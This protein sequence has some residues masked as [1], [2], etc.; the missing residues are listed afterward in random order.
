MWIVSYLP[1]VLGDCEN[2]VINNA[3]ELMLANIINMTILCLLL[4]IIL[5]FIINLYYNFSNSIKTLFPKI[6]ALIKIIKYKAGNSYLQ[7]LLMRIYLFIF[8]WLLSVT[9]SRLG[10]GYFMANKI[11]SPAKCKFELC[12]Y[13]SRSY[14]TCKLNSKEFY[15]WLSGF[16]DA[17]GC[18][19]I[20]RTG[21]KIKRYYLF[22]YIIYLHTD[23]TP[24]L[25]FIQKTLG[26]GKVTSM[27]GGRMS[28]LIIQSQKEVEEII[29]IFSNYT[30]QSSKLL[31]FLEFK[32]AFEL[33]NNHSEK[34]EELFKKIEI[35]KSRMNRKRTN[36]RMPKGH[37]YHITPNWLLGFTEG[38]GS[39]L[40]I[41]TK[42][43]LTFK[44]GQSGVDLP[45][46]KAIR[47]YFNSFK[48][49]DKKGYYADS[50]VVVL[51]STKPT[52]TKKS[53]VNFTIT[54]LDFIQYHLIPF[55]DSLIWHSK[56]QNDYKDFKAILNLKSKGLHHTKEGFKLI[57]LILSQNNSR[58]LSTSNIPKVNRTLLYD[59]I[60]KLLKG[61]SNFEIKQD[62]RVY[63]ISLNKYVTG[64]KR[65][66]ISIILKDEYKSVINTFK[67]RGECAKFLAVSPR[68]VTNR[69]RIVKPF[70]FKGQLVSLEKESIEKE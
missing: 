10:A 66:P 16:T 57:N 28:R 50:L 11:R 2:Y 56:K 20:S 45:L 25:K 26:L 34:T 58:R 9:I 32:K 49:V 35:I 8:W 29:K 17:E 38:E 42:L 43:R 6:K 54:N 64:G 52:D 41:K 48:G 67:T 47:V 3:V 23:D 33:Y 36:Y 21:G 27:K 13:S 62:G 46:M 14:S 30:L 7:M 19:F 53:E 65:K 39:F 59:K 51:T 68:T 24:V 44:L 1:N 18:F 40:V 70:L 60:E 69:L 61:P 55:F 15:T 5:I 63:I 22:Q 31:N 37:E 4:Y 12:H